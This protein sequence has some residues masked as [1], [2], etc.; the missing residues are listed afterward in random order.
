MFDRLRVA[1][2]RPA[3]DPAHSE[4]DELYVPHDVD[5]NFDPDYEPGEDDPGDFDEVK[6]IPDSEVEGK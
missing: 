5:D 3:V 4:D 2:S 1:L 6:D